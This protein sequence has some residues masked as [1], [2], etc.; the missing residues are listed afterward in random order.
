[1][2]MRRKERCLRSVRRRERSFEIKFIAR[3]RGANWSG[4]DREGGM[5]M[6]DEFC[7]ITYYFPLDLLLFLLRKE[8]R[9]ET[10]REMS[11]P[12]TPR[13]ARP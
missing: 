3:N 7:T 1:M 12:F 4:D 5:D 9:W 13:D 11:T 6:R 8:L 10:E 2:G